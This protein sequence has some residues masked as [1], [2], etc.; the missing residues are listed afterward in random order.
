SGRSVAEPAVEVGRQLRAVAWSPDGRHVAA[1]NLDG[2]IHVFDAS[3]WKLQ[4]ERRSFGGSG[5]ALVAVEFA[6]DSRSFAVATGSAI[7]VYDV[8]TLTPKRLDQPGVDPYSLSF[9][10]DGVSIASNG[11]A[12]RV[13]LWN[14]ATGKY[15]GS[16]P[17]PGY[18]NA[19]AWDPNGE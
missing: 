2:P 5:G 19:V 10:A 8:Q 15:A 17:H 1:V 7:D 6:P 11:A 9:R 16:F 3:T 14:V 13:H 4:N 12:D 18:V